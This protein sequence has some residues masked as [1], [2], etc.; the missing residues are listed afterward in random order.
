MTYTIEHYEHKDCCVVYDVTVTFEATPGQKQTW[1]HPADP[2]VVDVQKVVIHEAN[3]WR[4]AYGYAIQSS[5]L[6]QWSDL[7]RELITDLDGDGPFREAA[8]AHAN[9]VELG[10][11]EEAEEAKFQARRDRLAG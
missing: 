9:D 3:F 5:D 2:P 11:K 6:V 7:E 10:A 8:L 4:G 1:E